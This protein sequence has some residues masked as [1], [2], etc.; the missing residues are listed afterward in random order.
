MLSQ[1][2]KTKIS[3]SKLLTFTIKAF[4]K[5]EILQSMFFEC[6]RTKC[7][8]TTEPNLGNSHMWEIKHLLLNNQIFKK[9]IRRK[10]KDRN[11]SEDKDTT[12]KN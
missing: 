3:F 8:L 4:K 11:K 2:T 5:I 9:E 1:K 7:K 6:S 12:S 10:I